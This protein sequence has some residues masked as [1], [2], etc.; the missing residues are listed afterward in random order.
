MTMVP[1]KSESQRRAMKYAAEGKSTLKI[2]AKVG[3]E[4]S[5][6]DKGGA[7]PKKVPKKRGKRK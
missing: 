1:P 4:Y 7:L 5:A 3:K 2:P 6:S